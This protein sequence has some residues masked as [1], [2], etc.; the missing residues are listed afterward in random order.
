MAD[1][2]V[3]AATHFEFRG[4]DPV[5]PG[6]RPRF[7]DAVRYC[8][9]GDADDV[10]VTFDAGGRPAVTAR[11]TSVAP[12][13]AR[14]RL[15][16]A[17]RDAARVPTPR[18]TAGFRVEGAQG[19]QGA[20][21]GTGPG[22]DAAAGAFRPVGPGLFVG[23]PLVARVI[24]ATDALLLAAFADLDADPLAVPALAGL[25]TLDRAGYA[26][27]FPHQLT[28]CWTVGDLDGV[29]ALTDGVAGAAP[30]AVA[31]APVAATPAAC[32]NVYAYLAGTAVDRD[33]AFT[34]RGA[35]ARHEPAGYRP[36]ERQWAFT[37]REFVFAGD[38]AGADRFLD[39]GVERV[40]SLAV[41]LDLPCELR[42][43]TD[44]FF[45]TTA[46][47]QAAY[48]A[49]T[50]AKQELVAMLPGGR[51]LAVASW[52]RH[53]RH[54]A[55]A[56]ALAGPGGAPVHT[57]C[58]GFGLERWATWLVGWLGDDAPRV[59]ATVATDPGERTRAWT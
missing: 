3:R 8:V 47:A 48:Q 42:G 21:T 40:R 58:I 30:S 55:D 27:S 18:T 11:L 14:R 53:R 31:P 10:E 39:D 41:L 22:G 57:A 2:G 9:G 24:E 36:G 15:A 12:A 46:G 43:A 5:G 37:M 23:S 45:V 34:V 59:L 33:R 52:N 29:A 20:P 38:P 6:G 44:A 26:R 28:G 54:F 56:F 1:L 50:G 32:H 35:C 49:V 7:T 13:V 16:G 19:A 25:T 17:G 51:D 4:E